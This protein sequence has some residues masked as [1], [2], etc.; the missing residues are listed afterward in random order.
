MKKLL[1]IMLFALVAVSCGGDES[2]EEEYAEKFAKVFCDK[3]FNCEGTELAQAMYGGSES[4]CVK[5]MK[6]TEDDGTDDGTGEGEECENT[7]WNKVDQC[8]TCYDNLSCEEFMGEEETC[9]V[10]NETCID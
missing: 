3:I 8:I 1:V 9:P 2:K 5:L 10:C 4:E 7:D 6:N